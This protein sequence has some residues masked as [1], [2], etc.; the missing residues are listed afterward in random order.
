VTDSVADAYMA[1]DLSSIESRLAPD[2]T[3]RSPVTEYTGAAEIMPVLEALGHVVTGL[4]ATSRLEGTGESAVM[5]AGTVDGREVQG[6]FHV[7]ST[8]DGR[9]SCITLMVRP[10]EVLL[11]GLDAMRERMRG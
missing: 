5:F 7:E 9:V 10:L 11:A 8:L 3:F 2:A 6:V 4:R 1:G